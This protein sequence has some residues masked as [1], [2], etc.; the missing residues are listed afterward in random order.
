MGNSSNFTAANTTL[1]FAADANVAAAVAAPPTGKAYDVRTGLAVTTAFDFY[2]PATNAETLRQWHLT[3]LGDILPVWQEFTGRGVSV[4]IY[5]EGVQSTHWDLSANYDSSRHVVID[6]VTI[7][8]NEAPGPHGTSVAGLIGA[9]LNGRGGVGVAF[10][11]SLTSVNIFDP[12]SPLYVNGGASFFDAMS[13][14]NRYDVTNHS[15]GS[16]NP[17][18]RSSNSRGVVAT[19]Q[20]ALAQAAEMAAETGRAGLGT[21]IVAAAGNTPDDGQNDG[22]KT[23]RHTIAVS[24]YREADGAASSYSN[25]GPHLLVAAPSSDSA[26]IGGTGL[27]TTD[28]LGEAG[29]NTSFDPQGAADYTN[30]FGGTS[31]ATPIVTGVVALMLDAND[32]LG[33]RDVRNILA[34]SAKLPVA[35]E[36]GPVAIDFQSGSSTARSVL[37]ERS[38]QLA[39]DAA[40]WNGGAM[41]YSNDYGYG[42]VDAYNAVRMA[43]VWSLFGAAGT[44]AN[45]VSVS[46]GVVPVGLTSNGSVDFNS[47]APGQFA[48]GFLEEP[49]R[50]NFAVGQNVDVEHID[51]TLN[52]RM[53][54]D[55]YGNE[56]QLLGSA[57]AQMFISQIALVAPDGTTAFTAQTGQLAQVDRNSPDQEFTFGFSGF[58]GVA[59]QGE[60]TLQ[61]MNL[62][63]DARPSFFGLNDTRLTI[64]SLTMDMF[65]A[66]ASRDDVHSYTSEFF[67][68]AA[69]AGEG[70]RRTLSDTNGGNDWINA[71]AVAA[72]IDVSLVEGATTRFGTQDAFTIAANSR[73]ENVVTGDGADR[74]T[75]NG[76][77]NR[78]YGMRGADWLNGGAGNDRLFG[79][80]GTDVFAFD[81]AGISGFDQ[82]LDWSGGDRIATTK[83]LRG[84]DVTG[85]ITVGSNALLLLDNSLRGDTAELVGEGG[86]VLRA[87]G[88]SSGYWWY[89]FVSDGTDGFTDGRVMEMASVQTGSVSSDAG[90]L[91]GA[92]AASLGA[93]GAG[94]TFE[95]QDAAFYLYDTMGD[96]MSTGALTLA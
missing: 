58:R 52:F 29:Y 91:P 7:G 56:N 94:T 2:V 5:D 43:E 26:I 69:I 3:R 38:F 92:F 4:G 59:T 74:L 25:H 67:T 44:S 11:A 53:P 15:W 37:N 55:V 96:A 19:A 49:V 82:I 34:A 70:A 33:W 18:I 76:L 42:A 90:A 48:G 12:D 54:V 45:E 31:G 41:H 28:L 64:N 77:D 84:A 80:A 1:G 85:L 40:G 17:L 62:D 39:G 27:V 75:G 65:G 73:I 78:L 66:G 47:A 60:W 32:D 6:G 95:M 16:Y 22:W 10:N 50:F 9:A 14:M 8:G 21:I 93:S 81:T 87:A 86:A 63:F 35:F 57:F 13:Q 23:D 83:Q 68:M 79:G 20:N 46:T 61:F 89:D 72:N 24:A 30:Q 71:A 36:T 88:R 51:L